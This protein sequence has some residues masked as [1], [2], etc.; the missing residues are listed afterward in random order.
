MLPDLMIERLLQEEGEVVP[1]VYVLVESKKI[2]LNSLNL[3]K[4]NNV[5]AGCHSR[6]LKRPE[7]FALD[8]PIKSRGLVRVE[9]DCFC[10]G[11]GVRRGGHE[12]LGGQPHG[13]HIDDGFFASAK[14]GYIVTE[15][16]FG[17]GERCKSVNSISKGR[18]LSCRIAG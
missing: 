4:I 11:D 3:I 1:L 15:T 14:R 17:N 10:L 5:L 2:G 6:V 16:D 7:R 12:N 8:H 18:R 9:K 13:Q